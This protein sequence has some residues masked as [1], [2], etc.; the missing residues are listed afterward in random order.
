MVAGHSM[1]PTL[2]NHEP[3][4]FYPEPKIISRGQIVILNDGIGL[5]IKRVIALPGEIVDFSRNAKDV[6]VNGKMLIEPYLIPDERTTFIK[7]QHFQL[8]S[9]E[10]FVMGDNRRGSSDS[11]VYGPIT[12]SQIKGTL[13]TSPSSIYF[14]KHNQDV[15]NFIT[16]H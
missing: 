3:V 15:S 6:Y 16:K 10:Y 1:E 13:I 8:K 4:L 7:T 9:N 5:A 2:F 12:T 11:R 14:V